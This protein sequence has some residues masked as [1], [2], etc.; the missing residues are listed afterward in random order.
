M[1]VVQ[2]SRI[3]IRRG[4]KN[5]GSGI[6][7]LAGGELGWA[8]DSQELY[9]G[10]GAVSE[11]AP[12]VGNSKIITEHDNLFELASTY[13]YKT[14][15][16]IQTGSSATSP[17]TRTLQKRLDE[18]VTVQSFGALGD[19]TNQTEQ[20]QRAIDQLYLNT[21]TKGT[22]PSRVV[23]ELQPGT[24]TINNTIHIPPHATLIGAGSDKTIIHQTGEFPIFKTV[25]SL[26]TPGTPAPD[27]G[28]SLANQARKITIKGMTLKT[29]T[30]EKT[31]LDL[32]TCRESIF[33]DLSIEGPWI[34]TSATIA[35]A[36]GIKMSS[37]SSIVGTMMNTFRN[38]KVTGFSYAVK[39]DDDCNDNLFD[40]CTFETND[41][42][43][44]FGKDT[45]I[46]SQAQATGPSKNNITNSIF[47]FINQHGL[48][49]ENG[50]FNHSTGN[51]FIDVGNEGGGDTTPFFTIINTRQEGN[52]SVDDFFERKRR[53][54]YDANYTSVAYKSETEGE[55]D[56]IDNSTHDLNI[57]QTG[58]FTTLFRLPGD[59]SR[60]FAIHYTYKSAIVDAQ[61]T[62]VINVVVD[63]SNNLVSLDDEYTYSGSP[64]NQSNLQF[65][66]NYLDVNGDTTVDTVA[67]QVLN[68]TTNDQG[69]LHFKVNS[70]T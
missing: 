63:S 6:P 2:I 50:Q 54:M 13:T 62:G 15:S 65:R 35:D 19:G 33:E 32:V 34:A 11:G 9:I 29:N 22:V 3:Q 49:Y 58:S 12:A 17:V 44:V 14:G 47:K 8:V 26:S 59:A 61:R 48:W 24:Y 51:K 55:I 67:I 53:L 52:T 27:S 60:A 39:S 45:I 31:G 43:V 21:S 46:G 18:T 41:F 57:I 37:L 68:S 10:N 36:I 7:Q 20:L 4:Q 69:F 1:A 40:K 56:L 42:G 38:V 25:N 28:S 23:L 64:S 5:V 66:A 30:L 16:S 70:K